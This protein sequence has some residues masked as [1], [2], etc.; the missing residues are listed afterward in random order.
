LA[1]Q[2]RRRV[3]GLSVKLEVI[4]ND[5]LRKFVFGVDKKQQAGIDKWTIDFELYD[6]PSP[7]AAFTK[8]VG[9]TAAVDLENVPLAAAN[10]TRDKGLDASQVDYA[11]TAVAADADSYKV[12]DIDE[13]QMK[14]T[15][16]GLFAARTEA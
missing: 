2:T 3:V 13:T 6:R 15:V 16:V 4:T 7:T 9:I 1:A 14:D 8:A 10:A 5:K 12:R 11:L